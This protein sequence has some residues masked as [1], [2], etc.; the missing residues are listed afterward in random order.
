MTLQVSVEDLDGM[1]FEGC[2]G[3]TL[4]I[5]QKHHPAVEG[6]LIGFHVQR[7]IFV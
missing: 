6:F 5:S 3:Q 4:G 1:L 2:L 7:I